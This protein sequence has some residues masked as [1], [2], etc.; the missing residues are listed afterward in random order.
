M[1]VLR[2][3]RGGRARDLAAHVAIEMHALDL[4][5]V[6][7]LLEQHIRDAR[8]ARLDHT[9]LASGAPAVGGDTQSAVGIVVEFDDDVGLTN[10]IDNRIQCAIEL[11][12]LLCG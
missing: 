1:H 5:I 6:G 4:R 10:A 9:K 2:A 11:G 7:E 8:G 12:V 3:D